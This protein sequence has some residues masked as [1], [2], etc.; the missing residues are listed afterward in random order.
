MSEIE[1]A[2][3]KKRRPNRPLNEKQKAEAIALWQ[4]GSV[5]LS[6]LETKFKKDRTTFLRLFKDAGVSKGETAEDTAKQVKQAVEQ[7]IIAD[8]SVTAT[9]IRETREDVYRMATGIRRL[10]WATLL[11][12]RN[13]GLPVA[14]VASDMKALQ[15]AANTIKITREERYVALGIREDDDNEDKPLPDLVVQELTVEDIKQMHEQ[16]AR[17]QEDEL[18]LAEIG[19]ETLID[20]ANDKVETDD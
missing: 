9:R 2:P 6:D 19:D 14:T 18:G 1:K 10:V 15:L 17:E 20:E 4:S 16:A 7:A 8:A 11:K 12:A 3:E 13:E 5:S